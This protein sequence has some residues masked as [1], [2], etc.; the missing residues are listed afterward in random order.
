MHDLGSEF[1]QW[2]LWFEFAANLAADNEELHVA[3]KHLESK[4]QFTVHE[5]AATVMDCSGITGFELETLADK[6]TMVE[7]KMGKEMARH[8]ATRMRATM[9]RSRLVVAL[10]RARARLQVAHITAARRKE[11]DA[12]L[13]WALVARIAE[14]ERARDERDDAAR[15]AELR[16]DRMLEDLTAVRS[17]NAD[18][19]SQL[20]T[21]R[22]AKATALSAA[23]DLSARVEAANASL[24]QAQAS[25]RDAEQ[26]LAVTNAHVTELQHIQT[27]AQ[28]MARRLEAARGSEACLCSKVADLSQRLASLQA[29][30]ASSRA[31][32][33]E[34]SKRLAAV[35]A[36]EATAQEH[37]A[38]LVWIL[39]VG[40]SAQ[41]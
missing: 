33:A 36:S 7:S 8:R 41:T 13:Y 1:R 19:A 25:A 40:R 29:C 16:A 12:Q 23:A 28:D 30:D 20:E 18:L 21:T 22:R 6:L 38:M 15:L 14:A 2:R 37:L 5:I 26:R 4:E 24:A 32:L 9:K 27:Q 3:L 39:H 31:E 34:L 35:Q 10:R 17:S 11:A